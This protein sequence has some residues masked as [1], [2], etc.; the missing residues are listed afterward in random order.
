MAWIKAEARSGLYVAIKHVWTQLWGKVCYSYSQLIQVA[1]IGQAGRGASIDAGAFGLAARWVRRWAHCLNLNLFT[2]PLRNNG[3]L[4]FCHY[5]GY[6]LQVTRVQIAKQQNLSITLLLVYA[7]RFDVDCFIQSPPLTLNT[8]IFYL[9]GNT[10]SYRSAIAL[11]PRN[12][13][14]TLNKEII[15]CHFSLLL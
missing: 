13:G 14:S 1:R 9:D 2:V 10:I 5:S 8:H 15:F 6:S 7:T 3:R 11:G 4:F 12:N